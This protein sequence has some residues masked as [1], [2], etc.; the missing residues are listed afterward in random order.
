M[1]KKKERLTCWDGRVRMGTYT[2]TGHRRRHGTAR[3]WGMLIIAVVDDGAGAGGPSTLRDP[4]GGA[5]DR[6]CGGCNEQNTY[7]LPGV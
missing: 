5:G 7:L 3:H 6:R 4:M 2:K 1:K